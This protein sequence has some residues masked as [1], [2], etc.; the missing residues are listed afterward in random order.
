[1]T[2][3]AYIGLGGN[4]GDPAQTLR[5]ALDQLAGHAD[6]ELI[7]CSPFY[8]TK[9]VDATGPDFCNAAA[10]IATSLSAIQ[11]LELL[12][13]TEQAFGRTRDSW[14]APRTL[15]LDLL[16][17]GSVQI[18]SSQ[19]TVP[20]PRAHERAFVLVPLCDIEPSLM[21]GEVNGGNAQSAQAWL[22]SLSPASLGEVSPW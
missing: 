11:L 20:H 21:I 4:L 16:A 6:I 2:Q 3:R 10:K 15:D 5:Q 22:N 18:I 17:Y 7:A 9:P 13:A 19:L 14:H 1:M 12:L 8:R